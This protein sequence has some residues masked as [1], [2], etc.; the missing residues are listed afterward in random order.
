MNDQTE[1]VMLPLC[2]LVDGS[3]GVWRLCIVYQALPQVTLRLGTYTHREWLSSLLDDKAFNDM[4]KDLGLDDGL[5][6]FVLP[7]LRRAARHSGLLTLISWCHGWRWSPRCS[8]QP[9]RWTPCWPR[10]EHNTTQLM[11]DIMCSDRAKSQVDLCW[12]IT[13]PINNLSIYIYIYIKLCPE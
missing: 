13:E 12:M 1:A 3:L 2:L 10:N 8:T 9:L 6:R 7:V 11:D 4:C 5:G